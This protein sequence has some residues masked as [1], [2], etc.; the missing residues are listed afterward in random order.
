MLD[1][2]L[3]V[4]LEL[5]L[6]SMKIYIFVLWAILQ[7]CFNIKRKKTVLRELYHK[8]SSLF[9]QSL[10]DASMLNSS[11]FWQEKIN[12]NMIIIQVKELIQE[13]LCVKSKL[14]SFKNFS[15]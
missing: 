1:I 6:K 11:W 12:K 4:L 8:I 15:C 3:F 2:K 10:K 7:G 9:E 14:I 13:N 5:Y